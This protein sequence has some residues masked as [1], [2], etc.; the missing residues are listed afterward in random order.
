VAGG[1]T[2]L[3]SNVL[4][5][6]GI[7]IATNVETRGILAPPTTQNFA[8]DVDG[9]LTNDSLWVYSYDDEDRIK[10]IQS[11]PA[12]LTV[13]NVQPIRLNF[14]YDF[15]GRRVQKQ[16]WNYNGSTWVLAE[17]IVYAYDGLNLVAEYQKSGST[18]TLDKSYY[19]GLDKSSSLQGAGGIGGLLGV[20]TYLTPTVGMY[21][22]INDPWGNVIGMFDV[23][24]GIPMA[25]YEY[26]PFGESLRAMGIMATNNPWRF[27]TK[28]YD[29]ETGLLN[30]GYR[31]YS[32][33]LGRFINRDPKDELGRLQLSAPLQGGDVA[34]WS[35]IGNLVGIPGKNPALTPNTPVGLAHSNE[36]Q[37]NNFRDS[38][39]PGD[40]LKHRKSNPSQGGGSSQD[41]PSA[42]MPQAPG[43][44][45]PYGF[46]N[47]NPYESVDAFGLFD[48]S[49]SGLNPG[50]WFDSSGSWGS[51]WGSAASALPNPSVDNLFNNLNVSYPTFQN[52]PAPNYDPLVTPGLASWVPTPDD[53][54]DLNEVANPFV[55]AEE[56]GGEVYDGRSYQ[57]ANSGA[58]LSFGSRFGS[59]GLAI[60]DTGL[61]VLQ[62]LGLGSAAS[63]LLAQETDGFTP[64]YRAVNPSELEDL[65]AS[66]GV[67]KNPVNMGGGIKYFSTT[68]EGAAAEAQAWWKA[69]GNLYQ[70][71][72]TIVQTAFPTSMITPVMTATVDGGINSVIISTEQLPYLLLGKPLSFTPLP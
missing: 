61:G 8:Y 63:G 28:Y 13:T 19:W 44:N 42:D 21:A 12:L 3:L 65:N 60:G 38:A 9:N 54:Y 23:N 32:P 17:T 22:A 53:L 10:Q 71:P 30:F 2:L 14:T 24:V 48:W 68:P 67:F 29:K 41:D 55:W 40:I 39:E 15:L 50:N 36:Q 49:T 16:V 70:G 20:V 34:V 1:E 18:L 46:V 72:Y 6:G 33:S 56:R 35:Y 69:G 25:E 45:H 4:T 47:N 51:F 52:T 26:T 59:A 66:G 11:A 64:L 31:Y 43:L 27:S 37:D 5:L 57:E 58:Q 7:K 62:A